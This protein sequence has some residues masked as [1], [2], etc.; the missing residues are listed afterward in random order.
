M[1]TLEVSQF[2][3]TRFVLDVPQLVH[4]GHVCI[5]RDLPDSFGELSARN[6]ERMRHQPL[7]IIREYL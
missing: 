4:L 2:L 7:V 5:G 3:Q 1:G 6:C